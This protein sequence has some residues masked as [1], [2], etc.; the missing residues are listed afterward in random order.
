M[1]WGADWAGI[2]T[3]GYLMHATNCPRS[4]G[5]EPGFFVP[6]EFGVGF[7]HGIREADPEPIATPDG[8]PTCKQ[9]PEQVLFMVRMAADAGGFSVTETGTSDVKRS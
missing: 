1:P 9:T 6:K 2:D 5:L 7:R 3:L 8:V 4:E